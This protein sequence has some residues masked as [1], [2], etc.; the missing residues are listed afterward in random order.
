[1]D[2]ADVIYDVPIPD[3]FAK[4]VQEAERGGQR[5]ASVANRK[6][7]SRTAAPLFEVAGATTTGQITL[8]VLN[9]VITLYKGR[10]NP[11]TGL[12][13]ADSSTRTFSIRLKTWCGDAYMRR[14]LRRDHYYALKLH[15]SDDDADIPVWGLDKL[16]LGIKCISA[17]WDPELHPEIADT[18]LR[19][20]AKVLETRA[21]AWFAM[22]LSIGARRGEMCK[23]RTSDIDYDQRVVKFAA[24]NTKSRKTR[25]LPLSDR[26]AAAIMD[27]D[28]ARLALSAVRPTKRG[29]K[30]VLGAG[31]TRKP[32]PKGDWLFKN[33]WGE[34]VDGPSML[35]QLQRYFAWGRSQGMDLPDR[36]TLHSL[37]HRAI[38]AALQVN[39]EHAREMAGHKSVVTTHQI[40]GHTVSEDVRKTHKQTDVFE[41][42]MSKP[43]QAE[44]AL[45]PP[46]EPA[47]QLPPRMPRRQRTHS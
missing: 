43:A 31:G 41:Q 26:V 25:G 3:A 44:P 1:M 13:N 23:L 47:P 5:P 10:R 35:R 19:E 8:D 12:E 14:Y 22:A 18:W 38:S 39:P 29:P 30:P 24:K 6:I 7:F 36:F 32:K 4:W 20:E 42:V 11:N 45:S 46:P 33:S 17:H 2:T 27:M 15:R 40:Y 21:K 28:A 37:R 9:D 34:Q 16:E